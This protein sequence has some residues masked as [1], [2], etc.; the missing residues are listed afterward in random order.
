MLISKGHYVRENAGDFGDFFNYTCVI[1]AFDDD[2]QTLRTMVSPQYV[3][4]FC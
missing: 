4:E 3:L 1:G 2:T